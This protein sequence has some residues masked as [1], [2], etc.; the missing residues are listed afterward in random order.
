[1][2]RSKLLRGFL[3][4]LTTIFVTACFVGTTEAQELPPPMPPIQI[5]PPIQIPQ[6]PVQLPPVQT[7]LDQDFTNAVSAQ[8]VTEVAES[9]GV[10]K[11]TMMRSEKVEP[12]VAQLYI[13]AAPSKSE[14]VA[15]LRRDAANEL[16]SI[17]YL[18]FT[19]NFQGL[20]AWLG[21]P[22]G[23]A[24][25]EAMREA[26]GH[27]QRHYWYLEQI[28]ALTGDQ[29]AAQQ[30]YQDRVNSI[31][32]EGSGQYNVNTS[33]HTAHGHSVYPSHT[34]ASSSQASGGT[35]VEYEYHIVYGSV[36]SA[37]FDSKG[38]PNYKMG[39]DVIKITKQVPNNR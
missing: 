19:I 29:A 15:N 24:T 14:E 21:C 34:D 39:Y 10:E 30:R 13:E 8:T 28:E 36:R 16:A 23:P 25:E 9:V 27:L 12:A 33:D 37:G 4:L 18:D 32:F 35:H 22:D 2:L 5:Q 31:R 38:N 7:D 11:A 3:V 17:Q 6:I 20:M 26:R 1:M